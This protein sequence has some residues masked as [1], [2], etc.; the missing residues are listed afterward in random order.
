MYYR[1]IKFLKLFKIIDGPDVPKKKKKKKKPIPSNQFFS[2]AVN[3]TP[4]WCILK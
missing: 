4:L 2:I 3:G 1:V